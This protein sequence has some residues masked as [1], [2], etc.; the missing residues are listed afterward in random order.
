MNREGREA[1]CA[2]L[3]RRRRAHAKLDSALRTVARRPQSRAFAEQ[4][5]PR[6][7]ARST[8]AGRWAQDG[9]PRRARPWILCRGTA[10]GRRDVCSTGASSGCCDYTCKVHRGLKWC[11][12][13]ERPRVVSSS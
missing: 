1:A 9:A 8:V 6:S 11:K 3:D 4:N 10:A 7:L 13:D 2:D 12:R 5:G